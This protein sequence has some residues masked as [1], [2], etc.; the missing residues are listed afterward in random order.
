MSCGWWSTPVGRVRR[1]L[2]ALAA[3]QPAVSQKPETRWEELLARP[4]TPVWEPP[5][6]S[7]YADGI[8]PVLDAVVL[9]CLAKSPDDRYQSMTEL[10]QVIGELHAQLDLPEAAVIAA[11]AAVPLG[12]GFR[13]LGRKI[14][15]SFAGA[16]ERTDAPT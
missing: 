3:A 15:E 2:D 9:R 5:A 8:P 4:S 1:Y 7:A 12:E 16:P 13:S 11:P 10:Q 6:P 14:K